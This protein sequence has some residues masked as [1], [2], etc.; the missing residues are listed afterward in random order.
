MRIGKRNERDTRPLPF[1]RAVKYGQFEKYSVNQVF[2]D[3]LNE[4]YHILMSLETSS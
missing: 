4:L 3:Y 2:G 1:T